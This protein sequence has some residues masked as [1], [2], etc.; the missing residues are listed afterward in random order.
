MSG[1]QKFEMSALW[2]PNGCQR[3]ET[4]FRAVDYCAVGKTS[5]SD[6]NDAL[7]NFA[8]DQAVGAVG[9]PRSRFACVICGP[10]ESRSVLLLRLLQ[11]RNFCGS[12]GI[13]H[14]AIR[15][16]L[17]REG[18]MQ[19]FIA[20]AIDRTI[21]IQEP[22]KYAPLPCEGGLRAALEKGAATT[23]PPCSADVA[24]AAAPT[25]D[26]RGGAALSAGC[27]AA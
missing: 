4:R 16:L 1:R 8:R 26:A 3:L 15:P 25:A 6:R 12:D 20:Q 27:G 7:G 22:W 10:F 19:E 9:S 17:C 23:S 24:V 18:Q 21:I 13:H 5:A 2:L 14:I 11:K